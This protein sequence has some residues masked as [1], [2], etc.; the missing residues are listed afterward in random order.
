MKEPIEKLETLIDKNVQ[1]LKNRLRRTEH[2]YHEDAGHAWLKV[3]KS[4]IIM[5][6]IAD[7]ITGYSYEYAGQVYLEEDQDAITY[8]KAL[9]SEGLNT[10]TYKQFHQLY[11][12]EIN[13]GD[14]S[15]I[16]SLPNYMP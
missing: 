2:T 16:R 10:E 13:D 14:E 3:P 12:K 7:K 8:L 5:F 9:F 6:G 1:V 15:N 11:I 4:V